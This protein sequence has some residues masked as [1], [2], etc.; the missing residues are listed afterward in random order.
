MTLDESS[1]VS[2]PQPQFQRPE[3][4]L[5]LGLALEHVSDSLAQTNKQ[6]SQFINKQTNKDVLQCWAPTFFFMTLQT[7]SVD[8]HRRRRRRHS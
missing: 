6:S 1:S 7:A 3:L 8:I 5:K 2:H 4:E